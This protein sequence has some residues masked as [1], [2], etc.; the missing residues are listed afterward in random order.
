LQFDLAGTEETGTATALDS[1]WLRVGNFALAGLKRALCRGGILLAIVS[2]TTEMGGSVFVGIAACSQ[3]RLFV[4]DL[5]VHHASDKP[6]LVE[7]SEESGGTLAVA[8]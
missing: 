1:D 2:Q 7:I 6:V 3:A 4:F 8:R 5:R